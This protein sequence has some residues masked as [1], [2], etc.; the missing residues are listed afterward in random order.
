MELMEL[1][2]YLKKAND[3][4][5]ENIIYI[6]KLTKKLKDATEIIEAVD[7]HWNDTDGDVTYKHSEIMGDNGWLYK[8]YELVSIGKYPGV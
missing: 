8:L 5:E 3:T 6:D 1:R 7:Q 2:T 4:I